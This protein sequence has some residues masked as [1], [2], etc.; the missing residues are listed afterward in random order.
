MAK[1]YYNISG[2]YRHLHFLCRVQ[3]L[4]QSPLL[5]ERED[6][7]HTGQEWS[8]YRTGFAKLDSLSERKKKK[9][10]SKKREIQIILLS[11]CLNV[12]SISHCM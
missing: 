10:D 4:P 11:K 7:T 2:K 3:M 8:A 1:L 5:E 9:E 12:V 6:G